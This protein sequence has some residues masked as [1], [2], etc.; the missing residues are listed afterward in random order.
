MPAATPSPSGPGVIVTGTS[1]VV[2]G[3]TAGGLLAFPYRRRQLNTWFALTSYWRATTD[4]DASGASEAA[5][6]SRFSASGQ[7]LLRRFAFVSTFDIV[8]TSRLL[9]PSKTGVRLGHHPHPR[10]AVPT[11]GR[12]RSYRDGIPV[13][14][15]NFRFD[16]SFLLIFNRSSETSLYICRV[17]KN[18]QPFKRAKVNPCI[19]VPPNMKIASNTIITVKLVL[20]V[21]RRVVFIALSIF[22][23]NDRFG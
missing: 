4:T 10:K 23:A 13:F 12:L 19:E 6:I 20:N 21:R 15:V 17:F 22:S 7:R 11:G 2:D 9:D 18:G 14:F 16:Q 5:T 1:P 3:C 8:G